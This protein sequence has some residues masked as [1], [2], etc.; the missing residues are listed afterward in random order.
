MFTFLCKFKIIQY[1]LKYKSIC[2]CI[3]SYYTYSGTEYS[4]YL[5]VLSE[6]YSVYLVIFTICATPVGT[7]E[8]PQGVNTQTVH[9]IEVYLLNV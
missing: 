6:C 8:Q 1:T 7:F 3:L 9:P 5:S 4:A 2:I